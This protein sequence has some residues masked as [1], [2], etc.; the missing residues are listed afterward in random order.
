MQTYTENS[1]SF[2]HI[3]D[4]RVNHKPTDP[5]CRT[6][7]H[8]DKHSQTDEHSKLKL[9]TSRTPK[10]FAVLCM[11]VLGIH[12]IGHIARNIG[13]VVQSADIRSMMLYNI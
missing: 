13:H 7:K 4:T 8:P 10:T 6:D 2:S 12:N 3:I 1:S 9:R 11:E 5:N